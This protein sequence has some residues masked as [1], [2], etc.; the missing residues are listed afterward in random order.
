M[1]KKVLIGMF[2][3]LILASCAKIS[4]NAKIGRD[5]TGTYLEINN[6]DYFVCN[7]FML[8]SYPDGS[9]ISVK[10]Q[11]I[12]ECKSDSNMAIC[13]LYHQKFGT[14]EIVQIK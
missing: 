12:S 14:V 5:C 1:T 8:N 2:G 10:Y 13:E 4:R 11:F 9:V 3:L 6:K 7:S